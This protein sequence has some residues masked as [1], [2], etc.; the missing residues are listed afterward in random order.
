MDDD[1]DDDENDEK[2]KKKFIIHRNKFGKVIMV[3]AR[4]VSK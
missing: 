2:G 3:N 1:D 4:F